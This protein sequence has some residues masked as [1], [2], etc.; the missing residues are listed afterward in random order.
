MPAAVAAAQKVPP[1]VCA[2]QAQPPDTLKPDLTFRLETLGSLLGQLRAR[3]VTDVCLCGAIDRPDLDPAALDA[4]TAR[5]VPV[6]QQA[7]GQGDDGALRAVMGLFEQSG[8]AIR[9]AHELAP[10]LLPTA[11]VLTKRQPQQGHRADVA[12][13]LEVLADQGRADLGQACVVRRGQVLVREGEEG[14]DAM[15]AT[16]AQQGGDGSWDGDPIT[17]SFDLAG[18]LIGQAAD[19]L[20]NTAE[21][22]PDAP[23]AGAIL[24]KA[25]KPGQDWRADLPTIG[26]VTA[27]RA[28]EAGLDGIVIA[29]GGVIVLD[30]AQVVAICDAKGLFLWVR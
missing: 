18:D 8:F 27:I 28:A 22:S 29:A 7:L 12:T 19:W 15:L 23:G 24:F 2:L 16:L 10:G 11:G 26:P 9:A 6:L 3:G 13:A 21:R 14:T 25:P 1:L 5:L 4:E 17:W 30:R 20:S